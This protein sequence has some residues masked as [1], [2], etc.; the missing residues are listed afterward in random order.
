MEKTR[1]VMKPDYSDL[2]LRRKIGRLTVVLFKINFGLSRLST[3]LGEQR[4]PPVSLI[5]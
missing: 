5:F 4:E 1:L 2:T 3:E